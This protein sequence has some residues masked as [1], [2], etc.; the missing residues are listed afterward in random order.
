[1]VPLKLGAEHKFESAGSAGSNRAGVD[2]FGD[3]SEAA[4]DCRRVTG[5]GADAAGRSRIHRMVEHVVGRS[6]KIQRKAFGNRKTFLQRAVHF[7]HVRP[8]TEVSAGVAPRT[9][10]RK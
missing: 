8:P 7:K 2:D 9:F 4:A 3:S 5:Q 10:G 1:M 6:A